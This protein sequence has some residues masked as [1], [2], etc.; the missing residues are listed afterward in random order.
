MTD[1]YDDEK[2]GPTMYFRT[3]AQKARDAA[4]EAA[5]PVV[6]AKEVNTFEY[7]GMRFVSAM[8]EE[9]WEVR[10]YIP[11]REREIGMRRERHSQYPLTHVEEAAKEMAIRILPRFT[12]GSK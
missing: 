6:P 7:A 3:N 10:F 9:W 11:G 1:N 8:T 5:R 2:T 12:K 4:A